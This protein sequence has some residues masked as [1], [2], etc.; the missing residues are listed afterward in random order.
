MEFI[1]P[2]LYLG[3]VCVTIFCRKLNDFPQKIHFSCVW[4][5]TNP[6]KYFFAVSSFS[7]VRL[8]MDFLGGIEISFLQKTFSHYIIS[9]PHPFPTQPRGLLFGW[10]EQAPSAGV[11][12]LSLSLPPP[13]QPCPN[14]KPHPRLCT[15]KSV[16][17]CCREDALMRLLPTDFALSL[18]SRSQ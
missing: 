11:L 12:S 8:E 16:S 9:F 10:P 2:P 17:Q 5:G 4:C 6:R 3:H 18:E 14:P 1:D 13:Q 15:K 7:L